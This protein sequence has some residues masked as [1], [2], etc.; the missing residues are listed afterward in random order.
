VGSGP[1]ADLEKFVVDHHILSQTDFSNLKVI[2][3]PVFMRVVTAWAAPCSR[4]RC[5]PT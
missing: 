4:P 5:S 1:W 2:P 3:T